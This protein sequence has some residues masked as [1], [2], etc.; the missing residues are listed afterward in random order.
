LSGLAIRPA[1]VEDLETLLALYAELADEPSPSAPAADEAHAVLEEVLAQPK[2]HLTV[3]VLDG[4]V[5]GSAD[6][7]I[8][9]NLTHGARPWAIVEN[10]IVTVSA[11][12]GGVGAGLM[13]NLLSL[14]RADGCYKVQLLSAEHRR[15]RAFYES[16]GF[17]VLSN[18]FKLYFEES[19]DA[20]A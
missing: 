11:R 13:A 12:R 2:R 17:K 8:V 5:V 15:A 1:R 16:L 14:A 18:G 20:P 3:A 19:M 6:M 10:V 9:A 4:R 7:L